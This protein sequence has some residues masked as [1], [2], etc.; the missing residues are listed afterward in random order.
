MGVPKAIPSAHSE[1]L[2]CR[3]GLILELRAVTAPVLL[4]RDQ[5]L[6][7]Q[8]G[9]AAKANLEAVARGAFGDRSGECVHVAGCAVV[10]DRDARH[11]ATV[12]PA[13]AKVGVTP[14][15]SS[16]LS[17]LGTADV[18]AR[19]M[20]ASYCNQIEVGGCT[21]CVL[22]ATTA[23][24]VSAILEREHTN[25]KESIV[26]ELAEIEIETGE[27]EEDARVYAW[28]VEQLSGL[29]LSGVIACAAAS[30]VD[31]HEIARLVERGCSP[32]LALEIVR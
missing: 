15:P 27:S 31:W 17:F 29:V 1:V 14:V 7:R 21:D 32:E 19:R 25:A 18:I 16:R 6:R 26:N 3:L 12:P 20:W 2:E 28:R 24:A 10:D 11:I 23:A 8:L 13:S 30:F 5:Y 22:A 4:V 9:D